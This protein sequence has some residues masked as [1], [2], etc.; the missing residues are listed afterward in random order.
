MSA[1]LTSCCLRLFFGMNISIIIPTYNAGKT[2]QKCI[3]SALNLV[4]KCEVIVVDDASTDDTPEILRSYGNQIKVI[5][6]QTNQ[7]VGVSRGEGIK[8]SSGDYVFFLDADD[9]LEPE[10][11]QYLVEGADEGDIVTGNIDSKPLC[12]I[13]AQKEFQTSRVTFLC[14]RLIRRS[15]FDLEPMSELR[16]FED[17][18]TIPRLLFRARKATYV[19][20]SGYH[21]NVYNKDSLTTVATKTK[22]LVYKVL[23]TL[24]MC[25]YFLKNQPEWVMGLDLPGKL[26]TG[27][28]ALYMLARQDPD[29]F[30]RYDSET[31][32]IL[33]LLTILLAQARQ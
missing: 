5:T 28:W 13:E 32:T 10:A 27:L 4:Q 14:N 17:F 8:A 7:G 3:N 16:Y 22:H 6:H 21:Y 31:D 20:R 11:V 15:L 1:R 19:K 26:L 33:H 9:W 30:N 18:D 24:D 23:V 2:V 29:E 25:L 12:G